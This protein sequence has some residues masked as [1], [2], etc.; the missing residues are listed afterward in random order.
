MTRSSPS[1]SNY[2]VSKCQIDGEDFVNFCGL[3]RKHKLYL[4]TIK[5]G[6]S[7]NFTKFNEISS[8]LDFD[9]FKTKMKIVVKFCD[10]LIIS[11]LYRANNL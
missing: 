1:I 2:V 11:E 8:Y 5:L 10:L 6:F 4:L 9:N 3:F 7:E